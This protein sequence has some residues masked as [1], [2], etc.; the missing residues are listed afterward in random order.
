MEYAITCTGLS[1]R[2]GSLAALTDLSLAIPAGTIYGLLGP[3]GAGKTTLTHILTGLIH[4]S[5]GAARVAGLDV[6]SSGV[7]L[8]RRI[9]VL[10]QQPLFYGW[11][12]GREA[13]AFTGELFG[14]RGAPLR[15][16]VAEMLAVSGLTAAAN[17]RISGYSGGMR[18]RLGLALALINRPEVLFLDEPI[19]SLDPEGRYDLLQTISQLRGATTVFMSTHILADVERVCD[20]VA[21]L[22]H[23]KL[24][25]A[26][27][28][29]ELRDRYAQPIFLL[30]PEGGQD[31]AVGYL[32][33]QIRAEAWCT[34]VTLEGGVIR[35]LAR[36]MVPDHSV[37]R[38]SERILPL[39]VAA[40]VHLQRF[41]RSRPDLEDIFL[42]IVGR[43]T[44]ADPQPKLAQAAQ[45]GTK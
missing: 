26:A 8:R 20:H 37:T 42:Q 16:R 27:T 4:A 12:R 15:A 6:A 29:A 35:V 41:E 33:D 40:G 31:Q 11:M 9:G 17:R 14:L 2:Y 24:L 1:K 3:N 21:I 39:V 36:D 30:E 38:A 13:L 10:E 7:A 5:G 45:E 32:I 19:S 44:A 25:I 43:G 28:V 23:G 22:D 18:Q 34:R